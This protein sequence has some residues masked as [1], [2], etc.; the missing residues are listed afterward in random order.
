MIDFDSSLRSAA[1]QYGLTLPAQ[2]QFDGKIRRFNPDNG[3]ARGDAGWCVAQTDGAVAW[4]AFGDWRSGEKQTW[5]SE[6]VTTEVRKKIEKAR[7]KSERDE[8]KRHIKCATDA[9]E[10][11][12][13]IGPAPADHPYL[14][15][16]KIQPH[17]ARLDG[18]C[19]VVPLYQGG[20]IAS[21]QRIHPDGT[22][23]FLP[24]TPLIG[25]YS[26]LGE[27]TP[28]ILLCEG[29]ATAATLHE[30]TGHHVVIAWMAGNLPHVAEE[31]RARHP[32]ARIIV[33]ADQDAW[34]KKTG[35][36]RDE[37]MN[38]GRVKGQMASAACA[39]EFRAVPLSEAHHSDFNDWA[40]EH[41][42]DAVRSLLEQAPVAVTLPARP[43]RRDFTAQFVRTKDGDIKAGSAANAS[44]ALE[45]HP[46]MQGVWG[47]NECSKTVYVRR[48][49]PWDDRNELRPVTDVDETAAMIWLER[50]L[51]I[52]V[53]M[54]VINAVI[55]EIAQRNSFNPVT[56]YL[57]GLKWDKIE[58]LPLMLHDLLGAED[59]LYTRAVGTRFMISAVARAYKPGCK[60]DNVMVLEGKQGQHRKSTFIRKLFGDE[61]FGDSI[62]DI[63]HK[64]TSMLISQKWVFEVAELEAL[65]KKNSLEIKAW[66]TRKIEEYRPPYGHNIVKV[67]RA[68]VFVGTTNEE[69]YLKDATGGRRFWPIKCEE[70]AHE[71][72]PRDQLWAEAVARF[73]RG[74]QWWL[75]EEEDAL[76]EV[77]QEKRH[78]AD[79]WENTISAYCAGRHKVTI[80]DILSYALEMPR[81]RWNRSV[82]T[83]VGYVLKKLNLTRKRVQLNNTREWAYF[84]DA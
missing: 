23:L 83:R 73:R 32:E 76:A 80:P 70:F 22:K 48:A 15:R 20:A 26:T 6:R 75:T 74:E 35:A 72:M 53:G 61:N 65:E 68:C 31:T 30:A 37:K 14:Q 21:V 84:R 16:K 62:A 44:L 40:C 59:T 43:P 36:L 78:E 79:V 69:T 8:T 28:T 56:D 63:S 34:D 51:Q 11:W 12:S 25:G 29:W 52:S 39:G 49:T 58:R 27:V 57:D 17:N 60:V 7:K 33:C 42:L 66:L 81:E 54:T 13:R 67:P 1:A 9:N 41:G 45:Q 46:A 82:Q 38:V 19:L 24:G 64:D 55:N 50:T 10:L 4:A 71:N 5:C 2:I 18:E 77:E 47:Y 3:G